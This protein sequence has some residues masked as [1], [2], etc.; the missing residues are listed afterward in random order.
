QAPLTARTIQ[1]ISQSTMTQREIQSDP[2]I[3]DPNSTLAGPGFVAPI[4]KKSHFP[5]RVMFTPQ[6]DL[7]QIEQTNRDSII[8]NGPD[9][10]R[11]TADDTILP[12]RFNVPNQF[13]AAGTGSLPAGF[14]KTD[15]T[16][17]PDNPPESYGLISGLLPTAQSRGVGTL[18]GGIPIYKNG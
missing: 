7:S 10:I 11:G 16:A 8:S 18:P 9:G 4:G 5:P 17:T 14:Q 15:P 2:N 3:N 12:N 6:V 1:D 13:V